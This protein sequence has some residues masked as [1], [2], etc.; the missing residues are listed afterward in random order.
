[1]PQP[2][3]Q[4]LRAA[5]FDGDVRGHLLELP[6]TQNDQIQPQK[7]Y[8]PDGATQ[9]LS[10]AN[11]GAGQSG[12]IGA[13]ALGFIDY[14]TSS[15]G[16]L[17]QDPLLPPPFPF[18]VGWYLGDTTQSLDYIEHNLVDI[19]VTY[20]K[21]AELQS[22]KDGFSCKR[23]YGFRDRF[24]LVGP[25]ENPADLDS[26]NDDIL[27]MFNK[28]NKSGKQIPP[29]DP[30]TRFLSRYDKSATNIKES[31]LFT[32]IG[33]VPWA[34]A[35]STWYH[36]YA[37]FPLEALK[38]ASLLSEYTITDYGTYLSS[39]E[40]VQDDVVIYKKST[41]DEDDLLLNPAHVLL[42]TGAQDNIYATAF[43]RWMASADGGQ[44]VV[45]NYA[46]NGDVLYLPA[47]KE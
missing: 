14:V 35:Y 18:T 36:Q 37:R 13:L 8:G 43:M 30:P 33:Q 24:M 2:S 44:A 34:Y 23:I 39:P 1:M 22:L 42:R 25:E 47:P 17:R 31:S 29:T 32:L 21:A 9:T 28:I 3:S 45:A 16:N 10:I 19:A 40:Q 6:V 11:G 41:G 5:P 26:D 7:V 27:A 15:R 20:N 12:L 38:A 4:H 46:I